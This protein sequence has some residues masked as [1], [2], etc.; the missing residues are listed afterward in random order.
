MGLGSWVTRALDVVTPWNRGGETQRTLERKKKKED[1][2]NQNSYTSPAPQQS[3]NRLRVT[4]SNSNQ[5]VSVDGYEPKPQRPENLFQDLNK[6]L[7]LNK[8]NNAVDVIN[9]AAEP[10]QKPNPGD[11]VRPTLK[12]DNTER[13]QPI[14][15]P[16]GG[17]STG[18]DTPEQQAKRILER[19]L[20]A[21]KSWEQI[22]REN[23]FNYEAVKKY[24]EATR[25][26]YGIKIERPNQSLGNRFRDIFDANTQSDMYR[27][28]EGNAQ[29]NAQQ[30]N[31]VLENPGNIVS[32]TPVIGHATKAL[33][34]L[35]AQ[36]AEMPATAQGY[37]LTNK[38]VD[39]NNQIIE[40]KKNGQTYTVQMLQDQLDLVNNALKE[41]RIMQSAGHE[42][43]QK[44]KGGFLNTGTLYDAEG[45]RKGDA[46]TAI[47]DIALPTA[48]AML[49]LYTLGKGNLV[50]EGIKDGGLRSV[51][52]NPSRTVFKE[53]I[54]QVTRAGRGD[55]AKLVAGNYLSG[56]LGARA[57]GA[58]NASAVKSGLLNSV[59]GAVP[60]IGLPTLTRSIKTKLLP[61]IFKNGR[62]AAKDAIQQLDDAG[63]SASAQ[64]VVE[65][66][67]PKSIPIKAIENIPINQVDS[68]PQ[69]INVRNLTEPKKL[70]QEVSGDASVATPDAL[71][72]KAAEDAQI[73]D[74][75]D[76][77]KVNS[78]TNKE[79]ARFEGVTPKS[80]EAP[81]KLDTEVIAKGENKIIDEYAAELRK[82]GEGNGVNMVPDGEGGYKR[83]TNNVR[84]GDTQGKRM[85]KAMWRDEAER[86]LRAGQ[87]DPAAQKVFDD[88]SNPEVQSL[89]NKGEQVPVDAGRPIQVKQLDVQGKKVPIIDN[90]QIPAGMPETPGRVRLTKATAPANV[91]AAKVAAETTPVVSSGRKS[92]INRENF[93]NFE[94]DAK[95]LVVAHGEAV[96]SGDF[97]L[98]KRIED[99]VAEMPVEKAPELTRK[100]KELR[101]SIE[102]TLNGPVVKKLNSTP[103]ANPNSSTTGFLKDSFNNGIGDDLT[104]ASRAL[105]DLK[106]ARKLDKSSRAA[107]A[108][109]AYEK[110]LAE[111]GTQAEA[112]TALKNALGGEYAKADYVGR[113]F[114]FNS[115]TGKRLTS[116]IDDFYKGRTFDAMNTRESFNRLFNY[117]TEGGPTVLQPGDIRRV[118]RFF[119]QMVPEANLGD[120][121][122]QAIR[123]AMD[124]TINTGGK[125]KKAL[126]LQRSL[127]FTAD[128]GSVMRQSLGGG[129]IHP[130]NWA[131]SAK[132]G[133]QA[134]FSPRKYEEI[135]RSFE[136]DKFA[137]YMNDRLG[138]DLT[139]MKEGG[140]EQFRN[141][142]WAK[143]IPVVGKVVDASERFFNVQTN[144]LRY[145]NAKRFIDTA[146]GIA[147]LEKIA[148]DTS[149]PDTF[150]KAIGSATNTITGRGQVGKLG[151]ADAAWLNEVF[152]SPK[153]LA[154]RIQ[155]LNPK[156]YVDLMKANPAAGREA[157]KSLAVQT[158]VTGAALGAA[159]AAGDYE[160]GKIR[161][162]NTRYDITGGVASMLSTLNDVRKYMT[163]ETQT[164]PFANAEDEA[165]RWFKNQ[166]TPGINMAF[167]MIGYHPNKDG[168]FVDR[169]GNPFDAKNL[170]LD[171][172]VP[173]NLSG[174]ASDIKNG[175]SVG[176]TVTNAALNTIGVN[177]N[178]YQNAEDKDNASRAKTADEA[179]AALN[180]L[181]GTGLLD[182]SFT[183]NLPEDIKK[184][185]TS[186][187]QITPEEVQR[188]KE[189]MVKGVSSTGSDTAYLER[190]EYDTNLAV[191]RLKK[192]LMEADNT[193][194]P[195]DLKKMDVAIKRG[196]VYKNNSISY[197]AID[198]YRSVGVEE[199]RKMGDK[200]DDAYDPK[201]YQKLWEIDQLMTKNGV[202]YGKELDVGKYFLKDNKSGSGKSSGKQKF[203]GDFGKL[204]NSKFAPSIRAYDSID[205]KSGN[206][207]IIR[208]T[209]PNIVHK[210][211]A[212]G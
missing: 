194:K 161:I 81:Y 52:T 78:P 116:I 104:R 130:I 187:K 144:K 43:F 16:N 199:W 155:R 113:G 174:I 204:G 135:L 103:L 61:K 98:A 89:L 112:E 177:T 195:S 176:Q 94:I 53:G 21:G 15:L 83:V 86:Q 145:Y 170:V 186:G 60:D 181:Q 71:A 143:N 49:D 97:D 180:E 201:T 128:V 90:T 178:T 208:V 80:P 56:D 121:V 189:S 203:N 20:D 146:G 12:V 35:A 47:K 9:K 99:R 50:A 167:D 192:Q 31:I 120:G 32:R 111:G 117:G 193:T 106:K 191:L 172:L 156:W 77:N 110:V 95:D 24:S 196:E 92:I 27:R 109:Q 123:D 107:V 19:E 54:G 29:A 73:Q 206:I 132:E 84:F 76:F 87:A 115:D 138:I 184:L 13:R 183:K 152:T 64:A 169:Y 159:A 37:F 45:S 102:G 85:T 51:V 96:D 153:G 68:V 42:Q 137:N 7:T 139:M 40:A 62:F 1:E 82:L 119:N 33:N 165:T 118:R 164:T 200:E 129:L 57:E 124:E 205:V 22:A 14:R 171:N 127:L 10:V 59:L 91:E 28:Q 125:V 18:E 25:P 48:V 8:P 190:G 162:G 207:P 55:V 46:E 188:V 136:S 34:T 101:E 175:T 148:S 93:G 212:S 168:E 197:D 69:S 67:K 41:N 198:Q 211:S 6:A 179:N 105:R 11:V 30:K 173:V 141:A 158:A 149:S 72:K 142:D 150:L 44:N 160:N 126:G 163:G 66:T 122:E 79:V 5:R 166:L 17:I 133:F 70:I 140:E 38:M 134:M 182:E 4:D 75:F 202:S 65:G 157:L 154:A 185:M 74:A 209:R 58:N 108:Q 88:L 151:S 131:K 3:Q 210:I 114:D 26:N 23:N 100:L 63:I 2:Q 39:L 147:E 36:I